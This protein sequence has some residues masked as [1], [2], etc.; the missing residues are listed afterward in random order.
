MDKRKIAVLMVVL[1]CCLR[2]LVPVLMAAEGA[3]ID[4]WVVGG[5]GG[6]AADGAVVLNDTL[7]QPVI[8]P[9]SGGSV[10]LGAGYWYITMATHRIYLPL[11]LRNV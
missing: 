7:G 5:G 8:G 9:G 10:S 4:W 1:L 2:G 11:L 3:A 6:P